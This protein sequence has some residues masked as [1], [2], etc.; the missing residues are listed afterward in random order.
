MATTTGG[1]A[2]PAGRGF[3]V[4]AALMAVA[5]GLLGWTLWSNRAQIDQ[6]V[7]T[8]PDL[9]MFGLAAGIYL[10]ALLLTFLRWFAL[11]RALEVPFRLRDAVWLGFIGNV[12][13]LVIPGA[14]GGDL[15]KAVF[16]LKMCERKALAVGSM[17]IDRLLGLLGL[18]VLASIGGAVAWPGA[19]PEV[20]TLILLAWAAA[21]AGAVGLA[22]LFTPAL[23]GPLLKLFAGKGKVEDLLRELVAMAASYRRRPDVIV[24]ALALACLS[25][26][27]FVMAFT[28]VDN[29]LYPN[30]AP[31]VG[32][33]Y[34]I[35]PLALFTTAVPLPFGALGLT[36]KASE[37][38]FDLVGFGG[39]AVA[40]MGFRVLMYFGGVVSL[41]V[42]LASARQVRALRR[43][44]DALAGSPEPEAPE[45]VLG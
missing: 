43:E 2:R 38:L 15:I 19:R 9:R 34:V 32:R 6:V 4:N 8:R 30:S 3:L 42:Y 36:E 40:M 31:S 35:V 41:A 14:V 37:G 22:V 16:L 1:A 27:L 25:H 21:A 7:K 17:V 29:A 5:F 26:G 13:N 28:V 18:F 45:P 11:V 24:G 23:Y 12:F 39:G 10:A 20:R 33:H 44:A